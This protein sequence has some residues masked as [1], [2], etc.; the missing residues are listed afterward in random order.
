MF[1]FFTLKRKINQSQTIVKPIVWDLLLQWNTLYVVFCPH[2]HLSEIGSSLA[3]H[4]DCVFRNTTI[5]KR[6]AAPTNDLLS[7][8]QVR[9]HSSV[10]S[11]TPPSRGKTRSTSTSRW[12]MMATKSTSATCVR[13]PL[14]LRLSSKATRRWMKRARAIRPQSHRVITCLQ[15]LWNWIQTKLR[16]CLFG[17]SQKTSCETLQDC[18]YLPR[19]EMLSIFTKLIFDSQS[20]ARL[21]LQKKWQ[22]DHLLCQIT[23]I[24]AHLVSL[25][26]LSDAANFNNIT[27]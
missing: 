20:S 12:C 7:L 21:S 5:A 13:R 15:S 8:L 11:V 1:F 25:F 17:E 14:S 19:F 27:S 18:S 23:S 24:V 3:V 22:V 4:D 26:Y 9:G 16:L 2:N 6:K 10:T